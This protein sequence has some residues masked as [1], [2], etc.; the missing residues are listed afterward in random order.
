MVETKVSYISLIDNDILRIEYKENAMVE[1]ADY[2]ENLAVYKKLMKTDRVYVLTIA[3]HGA[4]PSLEVRNEFSSK[5]RSE[6]KIAE[7]FVLNSLAHKIIANFVMKVQ[8]PSHPIKFFNNE[9]EAMKWLKE[10]KKS[11]E[12]K[13]QLV[14][15]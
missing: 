9:Q 10:R 14:T 4:S 11:H 5:K 8:P 3:G 15:Y 12:Q 1:T 6:F 13:H 2:A 7:A